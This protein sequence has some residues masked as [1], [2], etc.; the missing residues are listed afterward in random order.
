MP[1]SPQLAS[2]LDRQLLIQLGERLRRARQK[3]GL[4][5][6]A[7]AH[8]V[9]ISRM[10][11]NAVE[12]GQPAPTMGTYLRV[13]SA[14]G[15]A[16]DLALLASGELQADRVGEQATKV[17]VTAKDA[18]H[19][20]QDLQSLMLHEAAV[21]LMRQRP[22][23]ITSAMETLDKWRSTANAHSRPLWDEWSVI[24]HRRDWRRALAQTRR[25]RELRQAS[26]LPVLLPPEDRDRILEEVR[27]L[28]RG[29]TVGQV[30]SVAR[31]RNVRAKD[32]P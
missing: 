30:A 3:Q 2:A 1:A 19:D 5:A 10:T 9:G 23:L 21:R 18:Q 15:M 14:L 31:A 26:P 6:V 25:S 22:E 13:M 12:A 20:V 29:V 4:T 7:L 17:V 8:R 32:A 28:K 24:L 16:G 11:L 27:Q